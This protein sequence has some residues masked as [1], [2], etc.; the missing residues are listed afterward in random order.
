MIRTCFSVHEIRIFMRNPS[1]CRPQL[2]P[3]LRPQL[4]P[5]LLP[6][7][8]PLATPRFVKYLTTMDFAANL[9][10]RFE[11][12]LDFKCETFALCLFV[13]V[14]R[15]AAAAD[16]LSASTVV[17][18]KCLHKLRV[19]EAC[20]AVRR[21]LTIFVPPRAPRCLPP[22]HPVKYPPQFDS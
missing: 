8:R 7:L 13:Y 21:H 19:A 6:Q 18:T 3:R 2:R 10:H 5:Q 4:R 22:P 1:R 14:A 16:F 15:D 12:L 17:W 20:T 9:V 11:S